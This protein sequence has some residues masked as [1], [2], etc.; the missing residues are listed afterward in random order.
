VV[1]VAV[2]GVGGLWMCSCSVLNHRPHRRERE[3]RNGANSNLKRREAHGPWPITTPL[4]TSSQLTLPLMAIINCGLWLPR[5]CAMRYALA[6]TDYGLRLRATGAMGPTTSHQ[7]TGNQA[8]YGPVGLWTRPRP[9]G[10]QVLWARP[11]ATGLW[12]TRGTRW[13]CPLSPFSPLPPIT[14]IMCPL[15]PLCAH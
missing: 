2:V 8:R 12:A 1:A 15:C 3:R 6:T 14:P 5:R 9:P 10:N 7:A 4:L 11:P 13:L